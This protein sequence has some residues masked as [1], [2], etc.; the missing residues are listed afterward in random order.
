MIHLE[1]KILYTILIE[2]GICRNMLKLINCFHEM[3]N[4]VFTSYL[5]YVFPF[6]CVV[7]PK[8]TLAGTFIYPMLTCFMNTVLNLRVP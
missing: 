8:V 4:S 2:F 5:F 3:S 7:I 1:G 6:H